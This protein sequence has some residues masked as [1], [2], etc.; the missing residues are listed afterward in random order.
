VPAALIAAALVACGRIMGW[1]GVDTAAQVYR[2]DSYRHGGLSLWDFRWFGGHWTLDYSLLYPPLAG[3]LSI[4]AV[5]IGSAALAALSFDRLARPALGSGGPI[6]SYL[7]AAGTLVTAS[8][9]QLTFLSGEAFGLAA[10]WAGRN[11]RWRAAAVLGL[12]ATL[13]SPLAGAFLALAA[14]AFAVDRLLARD[15][16]AR[17]AAAVVAVAGIPIVAAALVFPGDG[18]MPYPVIDWVWEMV[19]AFAIGVLAAI[20]YFFGRQH[21]VI[22]IG[23]ILFMMA[24]AL[25]QLMPAALGGNVGRLEDVIALPL[26]VG[27]AWSWMPIGLPLITVPLA[28]SQWTPAWGAL[29]TSAT[30]P[31]TH[32]AF[33][34]TLDGALEA[35]SFDGPSGR[36]E[37]VP[38]AYHWESAY[39][40]P[41][42]PLARG[43]ERQLDEA[44]NPLF[45]GPQPPGPAQ[46]RAWLLDNGVRFVALPLAPL[47]SAGQAEGDLVASGRVPGLALVWRSAEWRLYE[48]EQ[49]QGIV[50]GPAQLVSAAGGRVVLNAAQPG[51]V[52]VRIH[53]NPDWYVAAGAGCVTRAESWISVD[54]VRPGEVRLEMSVLDPG[55]TPCPQD[56]AAGSPARPPHPS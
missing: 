30:Q 4:A 10:L 21:R 24:A 13:T 52:T 8:I 12:A 41:V 38:T 32:R 26:A 23:V 17:G 33:Y 29:T 27:L 28:L 31:S 50:S 3:T 2:V 5:A 53:W 39:V 18:P 14:L 47:D 1:N 11:G 51:D 7:F 16:T 48:V 56:L 43:W 35:R 20:A 55:R 15:R 45:Y 49:S 6:A 34:A 54:V 37:V 44:D 42:M 40:A 46:Y 9:G 19:V 25:S 36:V 22:G